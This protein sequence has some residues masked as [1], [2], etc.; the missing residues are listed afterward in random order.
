M[1]ELEE[2]TDVGLGTWVLGEGMWSGE[3]QPFETIESAIEGGLNLIDT[4]PVYGAGRSEKVV[5]EA[6]NKLGVREEIFLATKCGLEWT[7]DGEVLRNSSET[8]LRKEIKDSLKRLQVD[9][10]DLY[11]VHWPDESVP[12]AETIE[13]LEEFRSEGLIRF[14]GLSNFSVD[15]I[16]AAQQGGSV[17]FLQPPYNLF[18]REAERELFPFCREEGIKTLTYGALCRGLLTGKYDANYEMNEEDIRAEDPK[19]GEYLPDYGRAVNKIESYLREQG[20]EAELAPLMI[21]WTAQ[22]PG[23]TTALVGARNRKQ[24]ESNAQALQVSLAEAELKRVREIADA[25]VPEEV[26]PE[27]MAPP[28]AD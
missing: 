5:G 15:Q 16:K 21:R 10:I 22:Q 19:F 24:A 14:I 25:T 1:V 7:E 6:L 17:E 11:Q 18:E 2:V 9:Q 8:R 3:T 4:A 12:F 28:E 23:V 20:Y 13:L 27:F 26:S